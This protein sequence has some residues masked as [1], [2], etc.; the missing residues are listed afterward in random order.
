M[1]IILANTCATRYG[2]INEKFAETVCQILE[3]EPQRLIKLKQIQK[4]DDRIAKPIIHIIYPILAINTHIKS[5]ILLFI[6]KLRN[7]FII[8]GQS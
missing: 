5:L 4:F 2:F 1:T 6:I 8:L 7:P 3:I